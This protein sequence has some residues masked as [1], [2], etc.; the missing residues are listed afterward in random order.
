MEAPGYAISILFLGRT[1]LSGRALPLSQETE[2]ALAIPSDD[3]QSQAPI[4]NS[5]S[6]DGEASVKDSPA[7]SIESDHT[8]PHRTA[9]NHWE[10]FP[11]SPRPDCG[12]PIAGGANPGSVGAPAQFLDDLTY[13]R[14]FGSRINMKEPSA[15]L[16]QLRVAGTCR[17][18]S[19]ILGQCP[20]VR[21]YAV[22]TSLTY[23][24]FSASER[25]KRRKFGS[26]AWVPLWKEGF[27]AVRAFDNWKGTRNRAE[28]LFGPVPK[29]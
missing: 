27:P 20:S 21:K 28:V 12:L 2:N 17:V 26:E 9:F 4:P 29:V 15:T 11:Q 16:S 3:A 7:H 6:L 10:K 23:D 13:L 19:P 24:M 18:V 25:L 14:N 5:R 8:D 22:A 1:D